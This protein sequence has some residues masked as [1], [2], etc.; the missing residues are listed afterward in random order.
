MGRWGP[1]GQEDLVGRLCLGQLCSQ[2]SHFSWSW[3]GTF[4]VLLGVYLPY[5]P[6]T[7]QQDWQKL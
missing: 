2:L 1:D 7:P 6:L 3:P 5:K 4:D